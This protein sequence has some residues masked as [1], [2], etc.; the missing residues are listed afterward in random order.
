MEQDGRREKRRESESEREV[1]VASVSGVVASLRG[2][3]RDWG[4]ERERV[5][6]NI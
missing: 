5:E 6:K 3:D 2:G 4:L 1:L